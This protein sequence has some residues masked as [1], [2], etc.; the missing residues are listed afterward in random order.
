MELLELA[1]HLFSVNN[2]VFVL[3][4]NRLELA[5]SVKALYGQTFDSEGYLQRFFDLDFRLPEPDR[6]RFVDALLS[7]TEVQLSERK[8]RERRGFKHISHLAIKEETTALKLLRIFLKSPDLSLRKIS[9]SVHRLGLI[10]VLLPENL[11]WVSIAVVVALILRTINPGLYVQFIGGGTTDEEVADA[12]FKLSGLG[13]LGS[14][15]EGAWVEATLIVS[16]QALGDVQRTFDDNE[17][18]LLHRHKEIVDTARIN[19]DV[20]DK[21]ITYSQS[22]MDI[23]RIIGPGRIS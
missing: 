10:L 12:I 21:K 3:V 20:Y 9:Q 22:V 15:T 17:S 7:R 6:S 11:R 18:L 5:Q 13:T 14:S 2:V 1:K 4:I 8:E 16:L 19:G 23:A